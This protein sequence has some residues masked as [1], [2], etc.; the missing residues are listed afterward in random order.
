MSKLYT[1]HY[2]YMLTLN[3]WDTCSHE[4]AY[5]FEEDAQRRADELNGGADEPWIVELLFYYTRSDEVV[6]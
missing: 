4:G 6:E 3:D 5:E 1:R 2:I